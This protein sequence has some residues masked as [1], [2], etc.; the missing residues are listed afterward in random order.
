LPVYAQEANAADAEPVLVRVMILPSAEPELMADADEAR[1][2]DEAD[3]P[4]PQEVLEN[5]PEA[6][7]IAAALKA[8][9]GD[10][11]DGVED[12]EVAAMLES[13]L[14]HDLESMIGSVRSGDPGASPTQQLEALTEQLEVQLQNVEAEDLRAASPPPPPGGSPTE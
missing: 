9:I 5:L 14:E 1:S 13:L 4:I 2:G 8:A 3:A 6:A 11:L 10:S 7:E 12:E